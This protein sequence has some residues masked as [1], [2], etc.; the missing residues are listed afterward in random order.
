MAKLQVCAYVFGMRPPGTYS[1]FSGLDLTLGS[2]DNVR[3]TRFLTP[4]LP[5]ITTDHDQI[6]SL[7][8]MQCES[9]TKVMHREL[10]AL[11]TAA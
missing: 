6:S 4:R 8:D 5:R 1:V 3:N 9:T 10:T 7:G 2:V 11:S